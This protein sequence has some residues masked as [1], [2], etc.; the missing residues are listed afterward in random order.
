MLKSSSASRSSGPKITNFVYVIDQDREVRRSISAM[1]A[2]SSYS[3]RPFACCADFLG[4]IA[5]FEAGLVLLDL[6][7]DAPNRLEPL[8]SLRK[9][10]LEWPII[11]MAEKADLALAV[12]A[13]RH[14]ATDFL[15]KPI[16]REALVEVLDRSC[17]LLARWL[18]LARRKSEAVARLAA[19]SAR[20]LDV[21]R[22]LLAGGANKEIAGWLKIS[23]RTVE[24]HRAQL[25]RRLKVDSL[26][27]L[28]RLALE[29]ELEPLSES[30]AA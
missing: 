14:G 11:A 25:M 30:C 24:A 2:T 3:Q 8:E 1:L 12:G 7:G 23:D 26:A 18:R 27:A 5:E 4:S 19:L 21:V 22:G 17:A 15:E 20:E 9:C 6:A 13:I 28:I 16:T 10:S 29:A